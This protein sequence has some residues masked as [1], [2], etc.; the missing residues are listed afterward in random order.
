MK[1][2]GGLLPTFGGPDPAR[3]APSAAMAGAGRLGS[4]VVRRP[5]RSRSS[6]RG[7]RKGPCL[8]AGALLVPRAL[9]VG[10]YLVR[11][12]PYLSLTQPSGCGRGR[13]HRVDADNCIRAAQRPCESFADR[14]VL[15]PWPSGLVVAR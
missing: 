3:T 1:I 14:P 15:D 12:D 8:L 9:S 4:V 11:K 5:A 13:S 7:A 10:W 6:G 2:R